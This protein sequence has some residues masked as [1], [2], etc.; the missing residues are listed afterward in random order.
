MTKKYKS[1]LSI[2]LIVLFIEVSILFLLPLL[3]KPAV[4]SA[5]T[6][7]YH[8]AV[9]YPHEERGSPVYDKITGS[10]GWPH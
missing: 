9:S 3:K 8:S 7:I 2:C 4:P 6:L 5:S 10:D 1:F